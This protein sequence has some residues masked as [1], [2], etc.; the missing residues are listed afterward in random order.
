[1]RYMTV[2]V[3]V[4]DAP[5][6]PDAPSVAETDV[7]REC[8]YHFNVLSDGTIVMLS[9]F[10]GDLDRLRERCDRAPNVLQY[11]V[12]E[13]GDGLAYI[14][15]VVQEPLKS[16]LPIFHEAE[17]II[18]MPIE[19]LTDNRIRMTCIG[20]HETLRQALTTASEI[21]S[22]ELEQMGEYRSAHRR[23]G[24]LL[25][26]RQREILSTAVELGYYEVPRNAVINDIAEAM[27]LSVATVGEHLQKIEATVLS[28]IVR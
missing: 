19:F 16:F 10:R 26:E 14:H 20:E 28:R 2:V 24:S 9:Q 7:T 22:I 12:P 23:L 17:I 15:C 3:D 8:M 21:V 1:M 25:T 5:T 11:D 4:E 27:E 6:S 13:H 18:D